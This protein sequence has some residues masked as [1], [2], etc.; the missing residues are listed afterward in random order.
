MSATPAP[1][2][3]RDRTGGIWEERS[4]NR[5]VMV[6]GRHPIGPDALSI[7]RAIVETDLGPLTEVDAECP[8]N[9]AR[10]PMEAQRTTNADLMAYRMQ[11]ADAETLLLD[12]AKRQRDT[13]REEVDNLREWIRGY[14]PGLGTV[15]NRAKAAE[16]ERDEARADLGEDFHSASRCAV[17]GPECPGCVLD[18][19][20]AQLNQVTRERHEAIDL[21]R[22]I[23]H[24]ADNASVRE[25]WLH[26]I[27]DANPVAIV[28]AAAP[29]DEA[30]HG[31]D[32]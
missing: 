19:V 28:K 29:K 8:T 6:P 15:I 16:A 5:L 4:D 3:H 30:E 25:R 27:A 11:L 32:R 18:K 24:G 26:L 12:E 20:R 7:A 31:A 10:T 21:L 9:D 22:T 14:T 23:W 1:K 17:E 13:A 2:R